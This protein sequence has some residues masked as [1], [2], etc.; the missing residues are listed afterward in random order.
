MTEEEF[1]EKIYQFLVQ[2]ETGATASDIAKAISS[3]RMTVT[4]YLDI[5]KGQDLVKYKG[6]GMAKLW[7]INHSP[8]MDS[9]DEGENIMLKEAMGLLGEGVVVVNRDLKI[10]WYNPVMEQYLGKL[11][12]NKGKIC[13]E[14]C[15][16]EPITKKDHCVIKTLNT[17]KVCKSVQ[18]LEKGGK[19][20]YF[21]VVSTPIHDK[22]NKVIG[23]IILLI[24]LNDY[25]RK[26]KE[27]K[28][29]INR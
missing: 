29:L 6:V 12:E 26:M 17:G 2:N 25:E 22:K 9:F 10:I 3:N 24:D 7:T 15:S 11:G 8:L 4:K 23:A 16:I 5:M 20:S 18:R 1:K 14:I 21:E 27:L 28:A 19:K 13:H